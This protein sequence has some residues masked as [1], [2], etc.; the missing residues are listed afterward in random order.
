MWNEQQILNSNTN[1]CF[2]LQAKGHGKWPVKWYAPECINYFKFSSKSDVWSFGV[3][4]W[5]SYS[6][7]QKPYKVLGILNQY[8]G[9][10]S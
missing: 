10:G 9:D 7:G 6:Y 4:M 5:E 8:I 2:L 1:F 3:L